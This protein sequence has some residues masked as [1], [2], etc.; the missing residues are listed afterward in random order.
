M[1]Y[2]VTIKIAGTAMAYFYEE[3]EPKTFNRGMVKYHNMDATKHWLT[4]YSN[5][6]MLTF[7]AQN[8]TGFA[9][10]NQATKELGVAQTKMEYWHRHPN[11]DRH[12]AEQGK[13]EV[14]K[15]WEQNRGK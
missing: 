9:E 3:N 10:R 14:D 4:H 8:E 13:A 6:K 1:R 7:F 2:N 5:A 12:K 15:K 11:F